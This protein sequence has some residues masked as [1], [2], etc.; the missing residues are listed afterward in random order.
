[1]DRVFSGFAALL[2]VSAILSYP[3]IGV[4]G[5]IAVGIALYFVSVFFGAL[6][7]ARSGG[8]RHARCRRNR[9]YR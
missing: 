3:V 6:G 5:F 8:Q 2:I 1:M 7:S 4:S 9:R